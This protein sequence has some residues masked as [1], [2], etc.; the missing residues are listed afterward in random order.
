MKSL[1]SL[2]AASVQIAFEY[3]ERSGGLEDAS[4]ARD[5]LSKCVSDLI[6]H[7]QESALMLSNLAIISYKRYL[8][9]KPLHL[10]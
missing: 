6:R 5:H 8:Q 10:V 2:H 3:L 4:E 9:Q 1:S 7:G